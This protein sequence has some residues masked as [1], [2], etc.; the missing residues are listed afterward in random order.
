MNFGIGA[1]AIKAGDVSAAEEAVRGL[2]RGIESAELLLA[3]AEARFKEGNGVQGAADARTA[4]KLS[5]DIDASQRPYLVLAA[6]GK[7]AK[8]DSSAGLSML[9]EAVALFNSAEETDPQW[10]I[11]LGIRGTTY[12]F[13]LQGL[14]SENIAPAIKLLASSNREVVIA[15]ILSLKK[16]KILGKSLM[17]LGTEILK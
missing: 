12:D 5:S 13:E 16:E 10:S 7:L 8:F 11:T 3:I 15:A 2:G 1:H 14:D 9:G 6:A 17:L 4:A